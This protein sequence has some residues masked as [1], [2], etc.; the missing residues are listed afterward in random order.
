[1]KKYLTIAAGALAGTAMLIAAAPA[2]ARVD[3]DLNIGVPGVYQCMFNRN[4]STSSRSLM[5]RFV[6]YT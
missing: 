1:M 5:S 2:M 4:P 6:R 3:V